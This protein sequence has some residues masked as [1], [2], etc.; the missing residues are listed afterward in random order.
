MN[1]FRSIGTRT[2]GKATLAGI[3]PVFDCTGM[4]LFISIITHTLIINIVHAHR[5]VLITSAGSDSFP[6]FA[7]DFLCGKGSVKYPACAVFG[8][9]EYAV[10]PNVGSVVI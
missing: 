5:H 3:A 8:K 6:A 4:V 2:H 9:S 7:V 1:E 10:G